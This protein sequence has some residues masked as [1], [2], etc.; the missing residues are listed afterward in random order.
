LFSLVLAVKNS[1]EN[2][3]DLVNL[4]IIDRIKSVVILD[5]LGRLNDAAKLSVE[6]N[7]KGIN[8]YKNTQ[9]SRVTKPETQNTA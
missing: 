9:H 8:N 1:K 6:D 3:E 7:H 5:V 4:L 2:Y